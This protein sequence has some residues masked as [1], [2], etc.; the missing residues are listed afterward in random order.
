MASTEHAEDAPNASRSRRAG[1]DVIYPTRASIPS[2]FPADHDS[3]LSYAYS[4]QATPELIVPIFLSSEV[5][6]VAAIITSSLKPIS[7]QIASQ[8]Q[9]ADEVSLCGEHEPRQRLLR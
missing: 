9:D 6:K 8:W 5:Q 3:P 1:V 4:T 2:D 7:Y